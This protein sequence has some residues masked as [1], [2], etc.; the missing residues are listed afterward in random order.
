MKNFSERNNDRRQTNQTKE[1]K[2][3]PKHQRDPK[4]YIK[5]IFSERHKN[6]LL[7]VQPFQIYS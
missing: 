1:N 7:H 6:F 4:C 3:G 5:S 2:M